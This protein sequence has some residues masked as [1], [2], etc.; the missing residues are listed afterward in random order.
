LNKVF[1]CVF[2]E[3][4]KIISSKP[5][6]ARSNLYIAISVPT[7]LSHNKK[8]EINNKKLIGN[9][10]GRKWCI[11]N[12]RKTYLIIFGANYQIFF[13]AYLGF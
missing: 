13:G 7:L 2:A 6:L 10:Y 5:T 8:H 11:R 9:C 1:I 12:V 3:Y 4:E